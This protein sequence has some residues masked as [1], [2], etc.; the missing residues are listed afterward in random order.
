MAHSAKILLIDDDS[1]VL[2][3]LH[4]L[5]KRRYS[6]V[7]K[8]KN[9]VNIHNRVSNE[10]YDLVF[11]DMNFRK[12]LND[13][14]E[15]LYWMNQIK[16]LSPQTAIVAMTA[17][18]DVHVAVEAMKRGAEDFVLK[19]W[20]NERIINLAEKLLKGKK[21]KPKQNER[22]DKVEF[23]GGSEPVRQTLR[24]VEKIAPTQANVL[25]LGENGTGKDLIAKRIHDQSSRKDQP[26]VKVDVG[27]LTETLFESELF[28]HV[29]GAFTDAHADKQGRFEL[30]DKG[31]LFLDEIGNLGMA[32]QAKLLTVLQNRKITPLGTGEEKPVDI[33]LIAATNS[34]IYQEVEQGN[35]RQDL[36]YRL[37]TVELQLPA[38]RTRKEDIPELSRFFLDKFSSKYSRSIQGLEDQALQKLI[39]HSWP[40]NVRELEHC[41]ERA[42]ILSESSMITALDLSF[43]AEKAKEAAQAFDNLNLQEMERKLILKA[44]DE[45]QGNISKAA[46]ELGITR[47]ALY[48]RLDKYGI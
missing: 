15:G 13:G 34:P 4:L 45:N 29:K 44:I 6:Q 32:Q 7:D 38:L 27:A 48:R 25:I 14:N 21:K 24:T 31:T 40:G 18:G 17:Y 11:L 3:S 47:T 9:S 23:I 8:E 1:D 22:P 46:K 42:V 20:E 41:L 37:N 43:T 16:N 12:G 19:P 28:G 2:T 30:A 36:L 35:F 5:L 10:S 33:R 26:F 39:Q